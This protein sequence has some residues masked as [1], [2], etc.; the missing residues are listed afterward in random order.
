MNI[1][2]GII[3]VALLCITCIL[4]PYNDC[5]VSYFTDEKVEAQMVKY[6]CDITNLVS[7][8][9]SFIHQQM[10]SNLSNDHQDTFNKSL[11][12]QDEIPSFT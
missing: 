1:C 4:P 9:A 6:I 10:E 2:S 8:T 3:M 5:Y 7:S 11:G 12:H